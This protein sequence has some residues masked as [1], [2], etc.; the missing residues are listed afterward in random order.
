MSCRKI[1]ICI[2][3]LS[4]KYIIANAYVSCYN[5]SSINTP[6]N[7]HIIAD[8]VEADMVNFQHGFLPLIIYIWHIYLVILKTILILKLIF[9]TSCCYIISI[10]L[11][12]STYNQTTTFSLNTLL[13]IWLT[14]TNKFRLTVLEIKPLSK[15]GRKQR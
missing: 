5:M 14:F 2:H 1:T 11:L 15:K 13:Q 3:F 4:Y 6:Y 9:G 10:C 12:L 7:K 8:R